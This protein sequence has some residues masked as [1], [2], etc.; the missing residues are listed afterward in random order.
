MPLIEKLFVAPLCN[1]MLNGGRSVGAQADGVGDFGAKNRVDRSKGGLRWD[2]EEWLYRG[3]L[4]EAEWGV[5]GYIQSDEKR[6]NCE[7]QKETSE[8]KQKQGEGQSF[9]VAV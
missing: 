3:P 7:E 1:D 9:T 6:L 8:K 4:T 5:V 2:T